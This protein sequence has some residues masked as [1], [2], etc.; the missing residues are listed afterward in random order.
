MRVDDTKDQEITCQQHLVSSQSA[1]LNVT[2]IPIT[3]DVDATCNHGA[4]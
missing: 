1:A 3:V 4:Q 2:L